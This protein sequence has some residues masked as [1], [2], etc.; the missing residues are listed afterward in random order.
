L[1]REIFSKRFICLLLTIVSFNCFSEYAAAQQ[2]KTSKKPLQKAIS[3]SLQTGSDK[4]LDTAIATLRHVT[5]DKLNDDEQ[6]RKAKEID[7]AWEVIKSFGQKGILRLKEEI[8]KIDNSREKDDYFKLNAS[9]LLWQ[10]GRLNEA[11]SIAKI[12]NSS[13]LNEQYNYVFYTAMDAAN[14]RNSK[15][16]P[17]LKAL[18]K[19]DKGEVYFEIHAM[20][21]ASP[22]TH[23]FVWGSYG[24][25][26]LPVLYEVLQTS[27]DPVESRSAMAPL[28]QALYPEALPKIREAAQ[29]GQEETRRLA[30]RCLGIYGH[31]QD[32][33]FLISGL[34]SNDP[35]VLWHYVYALYEY[36]DVR[37][38][39]H[40]VPLLTTQN[41]ALRREVLATLGHLMTP[42]SFE[43]VNNYCQTTKNQQEK[44][45]CEQLINGVLGKANLKW[46]DYINKT[47]V[48]RTA[49]LS[50][51]RDAN[52]TLKKADRVLTHKQ[53][54]EAINEW[55]SNH[56]LGT[57]EYGWVEARHILAVATADDIDLLLEAKASFY[58]RLS[59][60]CLYDVRRID[61]V[62]KQ[63]RRSRYRKDVIITQ[64]AD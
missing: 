51:I 27:V 31:P 4:K 7:A 34:H 59:D 21:V 19:D 11:E 25:K 28:C 58:G 43:A 45:T 63:L 44:E 2:R 12:W 40:L 30:I 10:I 3:P 52:L 15:V 20:N 38:V 39:P 1:T 29:G 13:A 36:E 8:K 14:T 32:Y 18:L 61:E 6:E 50:G 56:R 9:S 22:L 62:V 60:E 41:D 5:P 49:I 64:Q 48:E 17:M 47:L 26:G 16:I 35:K 23:E 57:K 55:T 37:A 46:A 54:L 53:L 24:I 33:E 42:E